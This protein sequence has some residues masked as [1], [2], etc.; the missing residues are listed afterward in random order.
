LPTKGERKKRKAGK[1]GCIFLFIFLSLDQGREG[2]ADFVFLSCVAHSGKGVRRGGTSSFPPI[3][4]ERASGREKGREGEK[5]RRERKRGGEGKE[6]DLPP[7]T[8]LLF[9]SSA[10]R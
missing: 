3:S 8:F 4:R 9:L 10:R 6:R 1:D 5:G 7:L 2:F